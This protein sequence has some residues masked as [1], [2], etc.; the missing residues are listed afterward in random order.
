[1]SLPSCLYTTFS[2]NNEATVNISR[3]QELA[4]LAYTSSSPP[5]TDVLLLRELDLLKNAPFESPHLEK[6]LTCLLCDFSPSSSVHKFIIQLV[7][8]LFS[9]ENEDNEV[10]SLQPVFVTGFEET[11][12][13]YFE[14]ILLSLDKNASNLNSLSRIFDSTRSIIQNLNFG[15]INEEFL[16]KF[17]ASIIAIDQQIRK[18]I[19]S[20]DLSQSKFSE[21]FANLCNTFHQQYKLANELLLRFVFI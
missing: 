7:K 12:S 17:L 14:S 11:L 2:F 6:L 15:E 19:N 18:S 8:K 13:S 10:P 3:V 16:W 9:C 4:H 21:L 1:M 20:P 5:G